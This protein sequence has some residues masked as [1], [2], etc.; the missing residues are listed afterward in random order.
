MP[1]R[2]FDIRPRQ[3]GG[4]TAHDYGHTKLGYPEPGSELPWWVWGLLGFVI[5][6]GMCLMLRE[7]V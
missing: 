6:V 3:A 1:N 4:R 5:V 7:V 2:N